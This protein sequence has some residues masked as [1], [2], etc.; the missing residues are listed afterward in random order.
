LFRQ[1]AF[2]LIQLIASRGCFAVI[3][4]DQVFVL[5]VAMVAFCARSNLLASS[6][7]RVVPVMSNEDRQP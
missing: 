1:L 5:V 6:R 2:L 7:F 4:E 3:L